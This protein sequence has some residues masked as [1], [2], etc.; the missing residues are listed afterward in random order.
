MNATNLALSAAVTDTLAAYGVQRV[1]PISDIAAEIRAD[2]VAQSRALKTQP[3]LAGLRY[4]YAWPYLQA[5]MHINDITDRYYEDT[6][7]SVV[8]Y[9]LSN[10]TNWR[11]D[12]AKRLKAELKALLK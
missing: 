5:M 8:R 9:F 7:D 6:A 2:M 1:R 10:A 3:Q 12:N 4:A 11:G